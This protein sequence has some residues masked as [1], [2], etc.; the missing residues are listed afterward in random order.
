MSDKQRRQF[1]GTAVV[2][3]GHD[4][5]T[6][7]IIPAR[8]LKCVTFEHLGGQVFYDERFDADGRP[9]QHPLNLPVHQGA[10]ILIVGRNFGCGSS[11]EHAPQAL[12]RWGIRAIL[13]QSFA[14]IFFAN[15][16]ALGMPCL[17]MAEQDLRTLTAAITQPEPPPVTVNVSGTVTV[18]EHHWPAHLPPS[19][20]EA[21]EDGRWAPLTELLLHQDQIRQTAAALPYTR[22]GTPE[23][24]R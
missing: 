24:S 10:R 8:F 21:F 11:R 1:R 9:T 14:E 20:R 6:D 13:G 7:R 5:D 4:I 23:R 12:Y 15:S 2:V 18:G 17:T 16:V 19:V 3:P 22:W